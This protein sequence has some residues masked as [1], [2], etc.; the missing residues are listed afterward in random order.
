MTWAI[1]MRG[2]SSKGLQ[3]SM[4]ITGRGAHGNRMLLSIAENHTLTYKH[5]AVKS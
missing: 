2:H 5:E 1:Y 4:A 3:S